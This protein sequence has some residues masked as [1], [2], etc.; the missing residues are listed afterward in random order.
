M[1]IQIIFIDNVYHTKDLRILNINDKILNY[2]QLTDSFEWSIK[3]QIMHTIYL[4][5]PLYA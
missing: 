4:Y 1:H 3:S 2:L 5:L